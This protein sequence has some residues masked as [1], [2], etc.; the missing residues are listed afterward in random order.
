[1]ETALRLVCRV[2]VLILMGLG[3]VVGVGVALS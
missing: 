1:M 2:T 3:V